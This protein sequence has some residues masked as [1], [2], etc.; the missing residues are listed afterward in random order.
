MSLRRLTAILAVGA[1]LGGSVGV[2][3]VACSRDGS[4]P[5][6]TTPGSSDPGSAG[7]GPG[8]TAGSR[9][10]D[11]EP[12]GDEALPDLGDR[13]VDVTHYDLDLR[14]DPA[15]GRLDGTA[16]IDLTARNAT[17]NIA[18]DLKDM[19][20]MSVSVDGVEVGFAHEGAKLRIDL[21]EPAGAGESFNVTV[22]YGGQP[23]PTPTRALRG[24]R[25]GW[26]VREGDSF[27]L[28]EP[29]GARTWYPVNEHPRDKATYEFS[30]TVPEGVTAIANGELVGE[31]E[32][33]GRTRTYRW[34]MADPMAPYLATVAVGEY[35]KF[36]TDGP[37][38]LPLAVWLSGPGGGGPGVGTVL[39]VQRDVLAMLTDR[40]GPFPFA[41]YGAVLLPPDEVEPFFDSVAI[42][43]QALSLFGAYTVEPGTMVHEAAHQWMGNS[44][45]LTDWSRD[46]WWV[47]GFARFSEW[48]WLEETRGEGAYRRA[49]EASW[50]ELAGAGRPYPAGDLPLDQLF[51]P[52]SYDRGALVFYSLRAE[53][54]DEVFWAAMRTFVDRYR[55]GNASTDDLVA[56]YGEASGRSLE[57]FFAAWLFDEPLPELPT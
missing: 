21:P 34:R 32:R 27:V 14:Y 10:E 13:D 44:V 25:V 26:Q 28:A 18:L 22:R 8:T 17:P 41:S 50:A 39:D 56:V 19:D 6:A 16:R 30:V 35:A 33:G 23:T 45:S 9:S 12:I 43:T 46:I 42:E 49:A 36:E 31:E 37:D 53:L 15:E 3:T 1:S 57:Q 11:P 2:G 55:H 20:V 51:S 4:P 54:G 24:V 47:E 48:L 5:V 52:W 38:G 7:E 29:E 40:L